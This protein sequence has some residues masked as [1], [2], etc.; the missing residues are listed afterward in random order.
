MAAEFEVNTQ[1]VLESLDYILSIGGRLY[2]IESEMK[3][4]A[5]IALIETF[6]EAM[7][8]ANSND[9]FPVEW[10]I[11]TMQVVIDFQDLYVIPS[12]D[13]IFVSVDFDAFGTEEELKRA[14]HQGARL[15][16]GGNVW[17]P[18]NGEALAAQDPDSAHIFWEAIRFNQKTAFNP[19]TGKRM[20]TSKVK[21]PWEEVVNKY[22]E[23]WGDKAPEWLFMQYGQEEWEPI[24][25][26]ID[27]IGRFEDKLFSLC[28]LL[29]VSFVESEVRIASSYKTIGAEVGFTKG[30]QPQLTSPLTTLKGKSYRKG[31]FVPKSF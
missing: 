22:V 2:Q 18:Y 24:I 20:P 30:G 16:G 1:A 13:S 5:K 10:Q 17:G 7:L 11:H 26:Q 25:P 4:I 31:Q 14:F 21:Y 12:T 19:S 8:E 6:E 23:I 29:L 27:I 28:E 9:G 15:E 3:A